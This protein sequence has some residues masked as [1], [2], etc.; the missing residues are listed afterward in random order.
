M[1]QCAVSHLI[2]YS[3]FQVGFAVCAELH[4]AAAAQAA[5]PGLGGV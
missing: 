5:G 2:I 4:A 1:A 3:A